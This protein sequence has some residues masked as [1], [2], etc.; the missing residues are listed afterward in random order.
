[1]KRI[2]ITLLFFILATALFAEKVAIVYSQKD[3]TTKE[4][5]QALMKHNKTKDRISY[6]VVG[7]KDLA[8]TASKYD[9]IL[10]ITTKKT[11][12]NDLSTFLDFAAKNPKSSL[13]LEYNNS[14][15]QG[16]SKNGAVDV[17]VSPTPEDNAQA[18]MDRGIIEKQIST[19]LDS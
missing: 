8:K 15:T 11:K 19:R 14:K 12:A 9:F 10:I 18:F 7:D 16:A 6:K 13:V 3:D 5:V 17:V 1:M 4:A 2:L